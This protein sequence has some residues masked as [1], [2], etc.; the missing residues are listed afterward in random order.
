MVGSEA[1]RFCVSRS[2]ALREPVARSRELLVNRR[3]GEPF[4]VLGVGRVVHA[5][6]LVL[7]DSPSEGDEH[8]LAVHGQHVGPEQDR[9]ETDGFG[10]FRDRFRG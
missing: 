1:E 2:R 5:R 7:L 3:A 6:Q 4:G 8:D 9:F 10:S